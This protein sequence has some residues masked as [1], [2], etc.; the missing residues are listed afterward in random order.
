MINGIIVN[1]F[2]CVLDDTNKVS[3]STTTCDVSVLNT[4]TKINLTQDLNWDQ[5]VNIVG[6]AVKD[7]LIHICEICDRPILIYGRM[8]MC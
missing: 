1:V 8:V 6:R 2:F 7:P 3:N 4:T 5:P